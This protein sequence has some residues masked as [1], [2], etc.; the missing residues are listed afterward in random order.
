[1]VLLHDS[2]AAL[3]AWGSFKITFAQ[4]WNC[5]CIGIQT[6]MNVEL[7]EN[8]TSQR[9][10][11]CLNVKENENALSKTSG[12]EYQMFF[13]GLASAHWVIKL[14]EWSEFSKMCV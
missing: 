5:K 13:L 11:D 9:A 6:E 1:M 8:L 7:K 4:Q 10:T 14:S 3:S 12:K 2:C